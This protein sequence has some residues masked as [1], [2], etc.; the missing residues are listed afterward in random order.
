[1]NAIKLYRLVHD[2]FTNEKGLDNLIWAYHTTA[3]HGALKKY[4]PG[5]AY[6]DVVGKS[7]YGTGFSFSE[8]TWAVEKKKHANKVIWWAEL[9][10]RGSSDPRRDC[11]DVIKKLETRY[12]EL[13]G[14][15]FWSDDG[16]YN[17]IGNDNGPE[18]MAHPKIVTLN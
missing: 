10:I 12:S 4:Y 13:A 9:G 14:F 7:A 3:N 18:L 6:V 8:Y 17:V 5:D 2:T 15:V 1:M 11:L 16:H